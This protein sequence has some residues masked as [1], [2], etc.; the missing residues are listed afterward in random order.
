VTGFY[1]WMGCQML[2]DL[3]SLQKLWP[4]FGTQKKWVL[5]AL[6]LLP[7]MGLCQ[8]MEPLIL[9]EAI[10][11]GLSLGKEDILWQGSLAFFGVILLEYG[12]R[13]GI[14]LAV[15]SAVGFMIFN[16]RGALMGHF[17]EL[18]CSF[19]EKNPSGV[20]VSRCTQD[21]DHLSES[22]N[23]GLLESLADILVLSG[24]VV[25][26]FILDW[27]LSLSLF[28]LFPALYFIMNWFSR[29]IRR[30]LT[31]AKKSLGTLNGFAQECL[32]GVETLRVLSAEASAIGQFKSH[33]ENYRKNQI[34]SVILDGIFYSIIEGFSSISMGI[35]I[36][37]MTA[38]LW[39][40]PLTIGVVMAY[41]RYN[42]K[43]FEPI[44]RIG[45][46]MS[47]LQ[48]V[49]SSLDRIFHMLEEKSFISG[50][51]KPSLSPFHLEFEDVSFSYPGSE[52][53]V[54]DRVTFSLKEGE[55]IALIGKTGSGK[56][57]LT[58]ILMKLYEGYRGSIRIQGHELRDLDPHWVRSHLGVVS[59]DVNLFGGSISYNLALGRKGATRE[60]IEKALHLVGAWDFVTSLP[61]G[62]DF[63]VA[64]DGSNLS[65]GE[66]QL[67][68]IARALAT[69]PLCVILDEATSALDGETEEI[70]QKAM[71][72]V[73]RV[74]PVIAIA[75]RLKTIE[76][77][78]KRFTWISQESH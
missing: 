9:K 34:R 75:H 69:D 17:M 20:L 66:R 45:S 5:L 52:E 41:L 16:L 27:R 35:L 2:G 58:K 28:A 78:Q 71:E 53:K 29:E 21:F 6:G 56:T 43:M 3:K 60:R 39:K 74:V 61:G 40:E 68:V 22:L 76:H 59:Q 77:C 70:V 25:G 57:T 23:E 55:S 64:P 1:L 72:S 14:L 33:N 19:H 50:H 51:E 46:T 62:L 54:L 7:L 37:L 36:L 63:M 32:F 65:Q 15:Y 48:G 13:M 44:K 11:Q 24:C 30:L 73:F 8:L 18:S 10:D 47:L 26:M 31:E 38:P 49:Y 42:Q 4:Y 67:L 12:I